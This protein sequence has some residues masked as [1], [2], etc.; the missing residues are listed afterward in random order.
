MMLKSSFDEQGYLHIPSFI[1][2]VDCQRLILR[3]KELCERTS[4]LSKHFFEA[5]DDRQSRDDFFL[6]SAHKISFFFD[7]NSKQNL[8]TFLSLNK[9]GHALHELC[10][11]FHKF[12]HQAKFYSLLK[13]LGHKK[14]Y[15]I[16]SMFIFKQSAFGDEV[17]PHQDASFLYTEPDSVIGLWFALEDADEHNGC[18]W[19]LPKGHLG[20]LKNRFV[21]NKNSLAFRHEQKV[22]WPR[23][24]FIP[25]KAR[26]GDVIILHGLLPHLSE[27]N[28]SNKTRFAYTLHFVD[29]SC[30]FPKTNWV[31]LSA[32]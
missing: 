3:M 15:P 9:V 29:R 30:Y 13:E 16:Q 21:R 18:L 17:P 31:G 22:Y 23:Q 14:T 5:G 4:V 11:V 27:K 20:P 19:V 26:A 1:S 24:S 2:Q 10:P 8:P 12:S 32:F 28:R 7:K 6:A 25:L